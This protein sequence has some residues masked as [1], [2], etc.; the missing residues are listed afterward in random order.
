MSEVAQENKNSVIMLD[1]M[2]E[3][4]SKEASEAFEAQVNLFAGKLRTTSLDYARDQKNEVVL[5]RNI[6]EAMSDLS[7]KHS[8]ENKKI[9][10]DWVK[11]VGFLFL[12]LAISQFFV[13][14]AENPIIHTSVYVLVALVTIAFSSI[15]IGFSMDFAGFRKNRLRS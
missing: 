14:N 2:F 10:S 7:P 3:G 1:N 8:Q 4:L 6:T 11:R 15:A 12:G 9:I 5:E 13:V